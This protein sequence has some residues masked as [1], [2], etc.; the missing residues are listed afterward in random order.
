MF[1]KYFQ[2]TVSSV[3]EITFWKVFYYF[4]QHWLDQ[5]PDERVHASRKP[6]C[7][8][9]RPLICLTPH[10]T[11]VGKRFTRSRRL[12]LFMELSKLPSSILAV[13]E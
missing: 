9:K 7:L 13:I 12:E 3:F 5:I 11:D 1:V 4:T 2:N 10:N 8:G 6:G